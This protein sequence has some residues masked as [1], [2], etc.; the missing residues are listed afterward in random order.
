MR[1]REFITLLGAAALSPFAASAQQPAIPVVALVSGRSPDVSARHTAGY[2]RMSTAQRRRSIGNSLISS[3][4]QRIFRGLQ[5]TM[6][7]SMSKNHDI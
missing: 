3:G 7:W 2:S 1:R 5:G 4:L 6:V